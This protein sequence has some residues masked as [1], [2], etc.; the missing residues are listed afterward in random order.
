MLIAKRG[1]CAVVPASACATGAHRR[2]LLDQL[3]C[4][5]PT[6]K[7]V[8]LSQDL[9]DQSHGH[10]L[11]TTA[12]QFH[13]DARGSPYAASIEEMSLCGGTGCSI[14]RA[15]HILLL[16]SLPEYDTRKSAGRRAA[17]RFGVQWRSIADAT[18]SCLARM[19]TN[20]PS[21]HIARGKRPNLASSC[22]AL[23]AVV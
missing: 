4:T 8:S 2:A 15:T 23:E 22:I 16:L 19:H 12:C 10:R 1:C 11:T 7:P 20:L 14:S 18:L 21:H 9:N 5:Q 17:L 13:A 6:F 3:A